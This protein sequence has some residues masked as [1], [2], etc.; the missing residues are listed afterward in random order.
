[1]NLLDT[2]PDKVLICSKKHLDHTPKGIYN[3]RELKEFF[4][5]DITKP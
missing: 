4:G 3:N 1:M 2:L 5:K